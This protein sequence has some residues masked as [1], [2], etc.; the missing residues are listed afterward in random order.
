MIYLNLLIIVGAAL[1]LGVFVWNIAQHIADR[2]Q[3]RQD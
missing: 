1:N 2:R 3:N